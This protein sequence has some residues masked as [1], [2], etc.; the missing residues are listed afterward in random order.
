MLPCIYFMHLLQQRPLTFLAY[1]TFLCVFSSFE[2]LTH[3]SPSFPSRPT[4]RSREDVDLILARLQT[5]RAFERFHPCVLHQICL[6]GF[7]ECLER[8][9]TCRCPCDESPEI[10]CMCCL[11]SMCMLLI[12]VRTKSLKRCCWLLLDVFFFVLYMISFFVMGYFLSV[13]PRRHWYQ[14]VRGVVWFTGR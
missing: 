5:L 11:C 7:Y 12:S 2:L 1:I 10:G 8:G 4:E 9:V 3:I 13:S 14:L 6:R